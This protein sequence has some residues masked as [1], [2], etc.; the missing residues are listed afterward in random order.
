MASTPRL[1]TYF[2]SSSSYRVRIALHHKKIPFASVPVNLVKG[3][4]KSEEY[5]RL[6]PMKMVPML[7][8]DDLV[9]TQSCAIIEYLDETRPTSAPLLPRD[10]PSLR[11][12]IRRMAYIF[13]MDTQPVQNLP[14]LQHVKRLGG[15]PEEWA[16]HYIDRGF[17]AAEKLVADGAQ[18]LVGKDLSFADICLI[19]QVYNA[20]RFGV[21]MLTYP[22][23]K[24]V[25]DHLLTLESV[26][27]AHP[28]NQSDCPEELFGK[29]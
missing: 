2:R 3:Y 11:A 27:K 9:L 1:H 19:P 17:S 22:K 16:Q 24:K 29:F 20:E 6:N 14:L 21:N 26:Q 7:E 25:A 4:Q 13:A 28:H 8:I 15:S 10:N 18:F 23:L 12:D 5:A